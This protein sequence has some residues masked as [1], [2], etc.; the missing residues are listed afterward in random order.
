MQ[1][2]SREELRGKLDNNASVA[3]IEVLG[4]D[5]YEQG[6]LPGAMNVP[7][8]DQFDE[9]IQQAVPD[10]DQEVVVYCA[11]Q[12]CQASPKAARRM[13]GLGYQHVH[14]YEAGKADWKTAGLSLVT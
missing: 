7:I 4:P 9:A 6:H 1:V 14:D 10:K 11:S 5:Q 3:L 12:E 2:I 8:G 13:D